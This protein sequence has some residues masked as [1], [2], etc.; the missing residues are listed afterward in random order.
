MIEEVKREVY[1]LLCEDNS[2]HGMDHINRVYKLSVKFAEKENADVFVAGLIALLHE[3]DDYKLFGEESAENLTNAKMIMN[4]VGINESVQEQ[5][6]DAI[7]K[8]GYK[9]ILKGVRPESL[10]GM[11]VSDADMCDGLGVSGI[12]R[13]YDYEKAHGKPFFDKNIFPNSDVTLENY[14]L[15]DDSA[16]CHCFRKLL[17]LKN[18][19][20]TSAGREEALSRHEI[21]VSVL[22]HLFD[23]EDAPE[24]GEYLD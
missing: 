7:K 14:K 16:V 10:E 8:I 6:I 13:T 2:G 12:L 18:M 23:E 4:K 11:I 3:V 1:K 15:C 24:W 19:M 22:Y 17:R 5:V 20:M 9:K 21:V